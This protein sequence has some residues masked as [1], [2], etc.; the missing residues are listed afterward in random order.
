MT[1]RSLR[2]IQS[3]PS[4]N[5][6]AGSCAYWPVSKWGAQMHDLKLRSWEGPDR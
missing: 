2:F 6:E 3:W 1:D 4:R 5:R